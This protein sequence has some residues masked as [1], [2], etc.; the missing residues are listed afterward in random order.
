MIDII[1]PVYND[2]DNLRY[3]LASIAMQHIVDKITVYIIDDASTCDYTN[4]ISE[5][6][7]KINME[8]IRL[9]KNVG[10]GIA[11]QYGIYYSKGKYICFM[12]SDDI[13]CNPRSIDI[14]YD[15]FHDNVEY[16]LSNEFDE[17]FGQVIC[18]ENNLHGK[19]YTR[20]FLYKNMIKFNESR[21]HED[22]YFNN[23]V[24]A[25]NPITERIDEV[26]YFYSYNNSSITA[27]SEEDHFQRLEKFISNFRL[28][29]DNA[30]KR[31]CCSE[32]LKKLTDAKVNYL[33]RVYEKSD[34]EKKSILKGWI[35]KYNLDNELNRVYST[36][37][38]KY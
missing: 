27:I 18:N 11:R 24:I 33:Q 22:E 36:K 26:T 35:K 19:M 30:K 21:F 12:D 38:N 10:P 8:Y 13:W 16:V 3:A 17:K 31:K 4:V 23:L 28:V 9:N 32:S 2:K 14:M 6:S 37:A 29:I 20:T 34:I 1:I 5:F 15:A 7:K 25:L